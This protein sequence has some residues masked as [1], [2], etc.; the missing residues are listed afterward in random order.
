MQYTYSYRFA[1]WEY[2]VHYSVPIETLR[3]WNRHPGEEEAVPAEDIQDDQ[4]RLVFSSVGSCS[5]ISGGSSRIG[6]S[7]GGSGSSSGSGASS[8]GGSSSRS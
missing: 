5:C 7:S 2:R 3:F 8:S 6:S 1:S 4:H